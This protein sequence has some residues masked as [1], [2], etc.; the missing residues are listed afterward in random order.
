MQ[1]MTV[2]PSRKDSYEALA[3]ST[4]LSSFLLDLRKNH[5]DEV[6]RKDLT[7][8][9]L[10]R[11]I[12]VVYRPETELWSHYSKAILPKQ[13][14]AYL[15]FDETNAVKPLPTKEIHHAAALD[16]TYPFGL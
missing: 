7:E 3:H 11:F 1:V 6:L 14:D 15:W 4:G 8:P 2:T 5:L 10:E 9:R 16:E 12:G 13:F